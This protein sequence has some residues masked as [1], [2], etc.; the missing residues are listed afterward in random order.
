MDPY[1][2]DRRCPFSFLQYSLVFP[3]F[4]LFLGHK[5]TFVLHFFDRFFIC[6]VDSQKGNCSVA[7]MVEEYSE[8]IGIQFEVVDDWDD[9]GKV[10][11]RCG[12]NE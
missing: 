12:M 6:L 10:M 5:K 7:K 8:E 1:V 2:S 9:L 4:S 11:I 3:Q